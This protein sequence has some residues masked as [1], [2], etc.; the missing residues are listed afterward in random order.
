MHHK[1]V[2]SL[3]TRDRSIQLTHPTSELS[4]RDRKV[5]PT[6]GRRGMSLGKDHT[7]KVGIRERPQGTTLDETAPGIAITN[8]WS[9]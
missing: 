6:W 1:N 8:P 5:V 2:V 4:L 7:S 3:N 9:W